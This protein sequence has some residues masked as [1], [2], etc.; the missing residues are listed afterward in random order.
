MVVLW[1]ASACKTYACG[2]IARNLYCHLSLISIPRSLSQQ[3]LHIMTLTHNN[4]W[5]LHRNNYIPWS[6]HS[7][8]MSWSINYMVN[9]CVKVRLQI[10]IFP[11]HIKSFHIIFR[12]SCHLSKYQMFFYGWNVFIGISQIFFLI[13]FS[14]VC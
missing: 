11:I 5:Y 3:L 12:F 14:Q 13:F 7:Y 9:W 4:K 10:F 1:I 6:K 8:L 2:D